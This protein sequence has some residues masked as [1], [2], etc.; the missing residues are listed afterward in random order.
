MQS[1]LSLCLALLT[2][3]AFLPLKIQAHALAPILL[4]I[5]SSDAPS[6]QLLI[7]RSARSTSGAG[8]RIAL[9][10]HCQFTRQWSAPKFTDLYLD[11]RARIRCA[12]SLEGSQFGFDGLSQAGVPV[13]IRLQSGPTP[14]HEVLLNPQHESWLVPLDP[15]TS[16]VFRQYLRSGFEHLVIGLDHVLLVIALTLLIPSLRLLVAT[17]T[18]FTLG[19]SISLALA[20]LG[21]I[22]LPQRPIEFLISASLVPLAL[23]LLKPTPSAWRDHLP[24]LA[25]LI[26]L[27]HGLGFA[28]VLGEMGLPSGSRLPALLAFNIGIE[29]AQLLIVLAVLAVSYLCRHSARRNASLLLRTAPAYLIGPIACYW[30]LERTLPLI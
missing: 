17:V 22:S 13:L 4:E 21:W 1:K 15:G 25:V 19:H 10:D 3:I 14:F 6:H 16:G 9:P 29:L 28:G 23:E 30:C 27:L 18:A 11:Q 20:T 8:L 2:C 5:D 24:W 26:G 12:K 7:R